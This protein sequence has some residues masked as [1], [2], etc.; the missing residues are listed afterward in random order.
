MNNI[1]H[2]SVA[3]DIINIVSLFD[4]LIFGIKF[5]KFLVLICCIIGLTDFVGTF[6]PNVFASFTYNNHLF[7][8]CLY[9]IHY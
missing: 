7:F 1:I 9:P 8:D 4:L 5:N 2:I 6:K 3:F